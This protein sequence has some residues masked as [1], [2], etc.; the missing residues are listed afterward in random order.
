MRF[1]PFV[2]LVLSIAA[3]STS[4]ESGPDVFSDT[5]N[6]VDGVFEDLAS[7]GDDVLHDDL[8]PLP[9]D[10]VGTDLADGFTPA[11]ILAE[12]LEDG[13]T[14]EEV[15]EDVVEDLEPED[16]EPEDLEPEDLGPPP[17]TS[18]SFKTHG[19][20]NQIYIWGSEPET[21]VEVVNPEGEVV[22][23]GATD[24]QGSLVVRELVPGKGYVVRLAD[25][26]EDYADKIH[27]MS[28]DESWPT[29]SWYQ[30]HELHHGYQYIEMRDGIL[31]SAWITL[32]GPE[33]EGPYPTLVNYSGYSPSSPGKPLSEDVAMFCPLFP[34]LCEAPNFP[35]GLIMGLMGYAVVG[36]N[37]RGTG[38]SGGAYD[39]FET[40]QLTDGYDIVEI[41]AHQD[42]VKH[43][44]V[45]M[46][47]LSYP[48]ISQLF[49]ASQT[50][51]SLAAIAPF[52]VIAK[53][54]STLVPGGILNDGFALN[55]IEHVLNKA[56]PYA[57]GWITEIVEDGDAI[58]EEHQLLH[59]QK[60]D[61]IQKAYEHP[62]YTD[63]VAA[64]VDPST[65]VNQINVPVFMALF[66]RFEN[67]PFR[68][69]TMTNGVHP[70]GFS[71]Q[72][73]IEWYTFLE[74]YVNRELPQ[75]PK[76]FSFLVPTFMEQVFGAPLEM[77][78]GRFDDYV[79]FDAALA[80]YEAEPEIRVIFES[81]AAP[82]ITAGAPEGTFE[83]H[84]DSWPI[85]ET[86]VSRWYFQPN[87]GLSQDMPLPDG[88]ASAFAH[89]P[90]AGQRKI[91]A[92]GSIDKP[93]PNWSWKQP[94]EGLAA[95]FVSAPL[96]EDH[97]FIGHA[98]AD[99]WVK[100]TATDADL[101][102][103]ITEV[104]PDGKESYIMCGWLRASF[105]KL[106]PEST[107]LR[108]LN[109]YYFDDVTPLEPNTWAFRRMEMMPF[110]HIFRA[111]SRIRFIVDTPGDSMARW[112]FNTLEFDETPTN[113]IGHLEDYPSSVALPL[114]PTVDVPTELPDCKALRGQPCRD[115]IEYTNTPA[116]D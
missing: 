31:L 67:A 32:P 54:T 16:L 47:G 75:S 81:G 104:R 82:G 108:P 12:V 91:L 90:D 110:S 23:S 61:V 22:F 11:E 64:P 20:I 73:L 7:V 87:G 83:A 6:L 113:T 52:S 36:V 71:P 8:G 114:I 5:G 102:V 72:N 45:G 63:D 94:G 48:G 65:F 21:V 84:F 3:C 98:S 93:Q 59:S 42:W 112:Q 99:L 76:D 49:T 77:P 58:C 88:G 26:P 69:F 95:S 24:Y 106:L 80:D 115:Y 56:A 79:D 41:V 62:Y 96:E 57:H 116:V 29:E 86:L 19:T 46:V 10:A 85:A 34:I 17:V 92:G 13:G 100:S 70:D 53:T 33:E 109:S 4:S 43:N 111:G 15:L 25:D 60:E 27:V 74:F 2:L 38:C 107:E 97:V 105:G 40:L 39:Y 35:S 68:H 37:M 66:D 30:K 101:E 51:P 1:L 28:L 14:P 78:D 18:E 44:K 50:P 55:W 9:V 89:D 103:C